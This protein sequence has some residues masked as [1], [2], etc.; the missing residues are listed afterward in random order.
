M[1]AE[2]AFES[3]GPAYEDGELPHTLLCYKIKLCD[4][5]V[6]PVCHLDCITMVAEVEIESTIPFG[7]VMSA[8]SV[9]WLVSAI[10]LVLRAGIE[11]ATNSYKEPVLPLN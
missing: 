8:L 9:P 2:A 11:P 4:V 6:I 3:A 10:K 5:G 1:V 7:C